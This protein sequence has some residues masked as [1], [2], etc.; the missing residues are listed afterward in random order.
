MITCPR[1]GQ[2]IAGTA[3]RCQFCGA[4]LSNVPKPR[5]TSPYPRGGGGHT[6]GG[7]GTAKWKYV[8]AYII[9]SLWLIQGALMF[10]ASVPITRT[11]FLESTS[12]PLRGFITAWGLGIGLVGLLFGAAGL[13]ILLRRNWGPSIMRVTCWLGIVFGIIGLL[14]SIGLIFP[15]LPLGSTPGDIAQATFVI[16]IA[17]FTLWI[18]KE[19]EDAYG[20]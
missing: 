8:V 15:I 2:T 12:P 16:A 7:S 18:L 1:C 3:L 14:V 9:G 20:H 4:D 11:G 17:V 5:P 6:R 10:I 13:G 19:T